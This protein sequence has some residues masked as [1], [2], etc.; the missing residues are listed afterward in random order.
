[1]EIKKGKWQ[2]LYSFEWP[3]FG[4]GWAAQGSSSLPII[5]GVKKQIFEIGSASHPDQVLYIVVWED[6]ASFLSGLVPSFLPQDPHL[7]RPMLS[8]RLP[9][10]LSYQ[11]LMQTSY[12]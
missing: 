10:R 9:S 11:T 6:L 3:T 8:K 7:W 12:F 4:A 2:I 5:K 1:M